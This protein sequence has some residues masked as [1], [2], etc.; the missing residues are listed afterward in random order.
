[1]TWIKVG[2]TAGCEPSMEAFSRSR[3][4]LTI[5][6]PRTLSWNMP[7]SLGKPKSVK[8]YGTSGTTA[9]SFTKQMI[10]VAGLEDHMH[11]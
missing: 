11:S 5:P 8:T 1:M 4:L 6:V 2:S 7:K 3:D 10:L 9:S